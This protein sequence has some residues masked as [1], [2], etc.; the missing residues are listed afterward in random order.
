[1]TQKIE[2]IKEINQEA[3]QELTPE[4]KKILSDRTR[5]SKEING[6]ALAD[7]FIT[8]VQRAEMHAKLTQKDHYV[9]VVDNGIAFFDEDQY[10]LLVEKTI[11]DFR[12]YLDTQDLTETQQEIEIDKYASKLVL[13]YIDVKKFSKEEIENVQQYKNEIKES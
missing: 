9:A 8:I 1:M 6:S 11:V 3:K 7:A 2:E 12:K 10:N 13:H 5:I 4:L